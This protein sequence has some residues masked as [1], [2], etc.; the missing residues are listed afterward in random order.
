V[1]VLT[2]RLLPGLELQNSLIQMS[3]LLLGA[4]AIVLI[5]AGVLSLDIMG[6]AFWKG[7]QFPV[8]G[9]VGTLYPYQTYC[10]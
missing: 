1:S 6:F 3:Q 4:T 9:K 10:C 5:L 7:N 8:E 2:C